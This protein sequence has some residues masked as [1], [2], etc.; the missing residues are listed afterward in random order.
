[1]RRVLF[2]AY[3]F[4]PVGGA[5]VQRSAKFARH[6]P[7]LGYEPLVVTGPGPEP[8][9][10]WTPEDASL[11]RDL[12]SDL[13]VLRI[14]H[15]RPAPSTGARARAERWMRVPSPFTA[16]W[17]EGARELALAAADVDIVYAS[18]SPYDSAE[19]AS[20]I[21]ALLGRPWVA[22]LR[23]PW[24]LDE[25]QV[26]PSG[27][28]QYLERRRMRRSLSSAAALVMNTPEA[29][30][31]LVDAFPELATKLIRVIP[32]GYDAEDFVVPPE[33]RSDSAFRIVHTGY[34]HTDL[35]HDERRRARLRRFLGGTTRGVDILARS[36]VF[37]LDAIEQI[38]GE[39]PGTDLELHL[40]GI[41]SAA[42]HEAGRSEA[43]HFR[44]YLPHAETVALMRSA[45][46]LFLPMHDLPPGTRATIVPGK[47]YEYLG[48]GRPILAAVPDGDARDL[49]VRLPN[50][51]LSRPR[52]SSAMAT[53]LRELASRK[54]EQ[55]PAPDVGSE[56]VEPYERRRLSA[57][58][59][60]V[61]DG[62]LA[63]ATSTRNPILAEVG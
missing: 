26:Y 56:L 5:G 53:I 45:D 41:A 28:H 49:L 54:Q 35:G 1:V 19:A 22:D 63:T 20:R 61:F 40:A 4:P 10:R 18:L 8:E 15:R 36:H 34:L 7:E 17:T 14:P 50:A 52:D 58:L 62:V 57:D 30:A 6:L 47:T 55:G 51:Y 48:S 16:W 12:P 33:P 44:G 9:D 27:L 39:L 38:R 42:D 25:M 43:V 37:V 21:A 59:A 2:L 32:N 23:D 29:A 11:E 13:T 60:A 46:L 24:A 3:H 31:R